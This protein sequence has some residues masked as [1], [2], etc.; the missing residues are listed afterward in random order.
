[1]LSASHVFGVLTGRNP[2]PQLDNA[3]GT[4]DS[5]FPFLGYG[6]AFLFKLII[7]HALLVCEVLLSAH[8]RPLHWYFVNFVSVTDLVLLLSM[9][10]VSPVHGAG[11][12]VFFKEILFFD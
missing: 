1:M 5:G 2:F 4:L 10:A 3:R 12:K 8:K 7:N 6:L 9:F 11:E